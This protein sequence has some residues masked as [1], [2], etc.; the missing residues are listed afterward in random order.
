MYIDYDVIVREW[1]FR[2]PNGK[3]DLNKPYHKAKLREVL[4]EL[5]L[6]I[7]RLKNYKFL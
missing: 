2:V 6:H 3:P 1:A 5:N 4:K 7:F